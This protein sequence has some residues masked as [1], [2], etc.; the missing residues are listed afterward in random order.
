MK[1]TQDVINCNASQS[2][3]HVENQKFVMIFILDI[4]RQSADIACLLVPLPPSPGLVNIVSIC[5]YLPGAVIAQV[6]VTREAVV[7]VSRLI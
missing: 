5:L 1:I 4:L 6:V 2:K 7:P 3:L